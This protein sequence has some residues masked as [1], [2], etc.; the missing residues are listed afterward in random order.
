MRYKLNMKNSN[1]SAMRIRKLSS[2]LVSK[3]TVS[4][5][6]FDLIEESKDNFPQNLQLIVGK[7][8]EDLEIPHIPNNGIKSL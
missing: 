2:I 6:F 7:I 5:R 1:L 8:F 4:K 3:N